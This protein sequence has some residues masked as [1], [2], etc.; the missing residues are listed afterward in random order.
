MQDHPGMI[1]DYGIKR[2]LMQMTIS[3]LKLVSVLYTNPSFCLFKKM[4]GDITKH[5]SISESQNL[6]IN[7]SELNRV[8]TEI[9][10]FWSDKILKCL[11][12]K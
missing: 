6:T 10:R 3:V 11:V 2:E 7:I 1:D 5:L 8:R 4:Q 9:D 12:R